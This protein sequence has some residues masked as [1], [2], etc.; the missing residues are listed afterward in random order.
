METIC[1][2]CKAKATFVVYD[3]YMTREFYTCEEHIDYII[4]TQIGVRQ[5]VYVKSIM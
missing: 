2:F 1:I 5:T 3:K 4:N